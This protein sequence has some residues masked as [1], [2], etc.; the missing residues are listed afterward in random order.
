MLTTIW[1]LLWGVLWAVYFVLDGFDLGAGTLSPFLARNEKEKRAV[2][3]ALGPVWNGNEVWLITAGGVTFAAFPT[4]Y[5]VMFSSLYS[6]LML[7]LFALIIRGV[8]LEFRGLV[9]YAGLAAVL[10]LGLL[11]G[12]LSAGLAFRGGLCQHLYGAPA[13]RR[14]DQSGRAF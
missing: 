9:E 13:Q 1:F 14:G 7:V 3:H 10:G 8:S 12:Q 2:Y 11:C 5:A 6:A 4:T